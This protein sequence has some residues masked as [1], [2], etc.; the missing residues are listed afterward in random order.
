MKDERV[1]LISALQ[2]YIFCSRQ[3]AL[4]YGDQTWAEN[5]LTAQGVLLHERVDSVEMEVRKGIRYD[6]AVKVYSEKLGLSGQLDLLEK[7]L[8][9]GQLMPVEYKRGKPKTHLA[10]EVQLC[11]QALCL[12][13]MTGQKI[14]KGALWYFQIRH[15]VEIDLDA[16]L[17]QETIETVNK[18]C[19]LLQSESLPKAQI[20][21]NCKA[22]SIIDICQ[23]NLFK[24]HSNL[25]KYLDDLYD[26]D[27]EDF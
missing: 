5:Y 8:S 2:H 18:V 13:E 9:S 26:I 21:K 17:R 7:D 11:A 10:D 14:T 19:E 12:E 22:C 6:R 1:V 24:E 4:I 16:Q 20:S 23:P 27:K 25:D 3:C 15:R